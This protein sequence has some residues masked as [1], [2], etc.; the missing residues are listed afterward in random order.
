MKL[1]GKLLIAGLVV[2]LLAPS[3]T[4]AN[5]FWSLDVSTP[6]SITNQD[7]VQLDFTTLSTNTSDEIT[8]ELYRNGTLVDEI[9][10][11]GGGDSGR[12]VAQLPRDGSYTLEVRA[13]NSNGS[14]PQTKTRSI[15]RDTTPPASPNYAGATRDNGIYTVRFSARDSDTARIYLFSSTN[16]SFTANENTLEGYV[17]ATGST[18]RITYQAPS[19]APRY[20]AVVAVDQAGNISRAVGDPETEVEIREGAI[21]APGTPGISPATTTPGTSP[22]TAPGTSPGDAADDPTATEADGDETATEDEDVLG[23]EDDEEEGEVAGEA[24]EASSVWL[25]LLALAALAA[26]GYFYYSKQSKDNA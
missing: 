10:T 7:R 16:R 9:V 20:H 26:A 8:V 5:S 19:S 3:A 1:L 4:L 17:V 25:W 11:T 6:R 13:T 14:D 18:Q 21:P 15:T 23:V 22:G 2:A 12:L 24:D